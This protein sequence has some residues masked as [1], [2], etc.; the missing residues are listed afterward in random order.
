MNFKIIVQKELYI[1]QHFAKV[2]I[3]LQH[4]INNQKFLKSTHLCSLHRPLNYVTS[5]VIQQPTVMILSA[6]CIYFTT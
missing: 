1:L 4:K 3:V 6:C 5:E 2:G